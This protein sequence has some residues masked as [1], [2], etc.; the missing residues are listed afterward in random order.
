M[1]RFAM[2]EIKNFEI[3]CMIELKQLGEQKVFQDLYFY[4]YQIYASGIGVKL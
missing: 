4:S 1:N 2:S 3:W